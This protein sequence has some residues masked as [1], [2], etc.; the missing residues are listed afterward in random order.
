MVNTA[1]YGAV[2]QKIDYQLDT[3]GASTNNET[4]CGVPEYSITVL[5]KDVQTF[6]GEYKSFIYLDSNNIDFSDVGVWD[7]S[8]TA[9]LPRYPTATFTATF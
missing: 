8:L 1:L 6:V 9:T 5:N 4:F 2:I 3:V 7:V